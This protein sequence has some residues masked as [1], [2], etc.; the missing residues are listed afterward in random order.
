[1]LQAAP[2]PY[3]GWLRGVS[4]A[5]QVRHSGFDDPLGTAGFGGGPGWADAFGKIDVHG[6]RPQIEL[7]RDAG[8]NLIDTAAARKRLRSSAIGPVGDRQNEDSLR[9]RR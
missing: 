4:T 3:V 7:A 8:V 6:A 1:M 5:G 9:R 2:D